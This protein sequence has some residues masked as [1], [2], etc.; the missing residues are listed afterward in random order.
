MALSG[1]P[2]REELLRRI[3]RLEAQVAELQRRTGARGAR[4]YKSKARI[5]SWPLVHIASGMD[6]VT[7]KP[8]VARG[9]IALG[10]VAIGVFAMGGAAFGG[11][12]VGGFAVGLISFAGMALGFLLSFGGLSIGTVAIGGL[13]VGWL[14][15]GGVALGYYGVGGAAAVAHSLDEFLRNPAIPEVLR[16]VIQPLSGAG[17]G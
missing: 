10:D 7:G 13:A 14:V 5:G 12:A 6:P 15:W 9:V 4:E 2:D 17:H 16:R 3:A 11:I 1:D 8:L